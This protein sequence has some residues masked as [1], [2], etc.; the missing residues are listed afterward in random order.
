MFD[1]LHVLTASV[2]RLW[3]LVLA[4]DIVYAQ[5]SGNWDCDDQGG[6][7]VMLGLGLRRSGPGSGKREYRCAV[8]HVEPQLI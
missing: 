2:G 4:H 8:L 7:A 3:Q 6:D 5:G 1:G